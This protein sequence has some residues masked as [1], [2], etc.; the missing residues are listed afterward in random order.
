MPSLLSEIVELELG[1]FCDKCRGRVLSSL[2]PEV[3]LTP[4]LLFVFR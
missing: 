1:P 2:I 4:G 3:V